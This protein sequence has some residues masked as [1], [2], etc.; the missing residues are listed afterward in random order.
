[1][2]YH[3]DRN[4]GEKLAEEKFKEV[5]NAYDTLSDPNKRAQY[6][7]TLRKPKSIRRPEKNK[8]PYRG[9]GFT[10]SD[11]PPPKTDIWGDPIQ[12]EHKWVD[13][14]AGKYENGGLPDIR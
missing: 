1:M 14:F 5:Q 9:D 11:A 8:R 12:P 2:K 4:P 3:P 7:L 13:S 10:Y 6:D